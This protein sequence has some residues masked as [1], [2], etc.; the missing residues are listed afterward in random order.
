MFKIEWQEQSG[1]IG[2]VEWESEKELITH[3]NNDPECAN[4][5][6][7]EYPDG[8]SNVDEAIEVIYHDYRYAKI[9]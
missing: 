4:Y 6:E 2:R 1:R 7:R 8:V 3:A 9:V 5:L